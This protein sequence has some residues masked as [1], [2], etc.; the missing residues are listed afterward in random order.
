[1]QFEFGLVWQDSGICFSVRK[2]SGFFLVE[3][4]PIEPSGLVDLA[5]SGV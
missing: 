1:M 5:V 2:P 3:S 4:T